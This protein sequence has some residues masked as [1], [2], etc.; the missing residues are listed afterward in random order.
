MPFTLKEPSRGVP[1]AEKDTAI[2][3]FTAL[4]E[5]SAKSA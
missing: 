1:L 5:S 2:G 4:V 3:D